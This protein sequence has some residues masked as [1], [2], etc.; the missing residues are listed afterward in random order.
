MLV[1]GFNSMRDPQTLVA[2]LRDLRE[3]MKSLPDDAVVVYEDGGFHVPELSEHVREGLGDL[4]DVHSMNEDEM[5]TY[6]GR[7]V[8]LLDPADV[9]AA[10]GDLGRV[11]RARTVVVHSGYWALAVGERAGAYRAALDCG[12]LL[13]STRYLHGDA[14]TA[15]DHSRSAEIPRHAAGSAFA[16][17]VEH[18]LPGQVCAVPALVLRTARPTTIGLGDTF[19]GGFVA[20]LAGAG[21]GVADGAA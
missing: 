8:D 9:V 11:A 14:F 19:V 3:Q 12:I 20:A 18:A 16:R 10:L 7:T 17:A 21:C 13:A 15:S 2:R 6:V 4:V 1:S 5:Q